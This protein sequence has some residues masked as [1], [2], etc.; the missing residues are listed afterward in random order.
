M[1]KKA[2]VFVFGSN[3]AGIHGGGAAAH[4][5]EILG[6]EWGKGVGMTGQCYALPTKDY[7]IRTLKLPEVKHY[8]NEFI[9]FAA[10]HHNLEFKVTAVGCGLAG[11]TKDDIAP[12][13][14]SAPHNCLMPPEWKG[15]KELDGKKFWTY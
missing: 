7:M 4:A 14:E 10:D 12:L 6:A 2:Q 9:G 15:M 11:Y 13:F 1:A 8:V 5:H 3:L